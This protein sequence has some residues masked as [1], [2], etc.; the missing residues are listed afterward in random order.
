MTDVVKLLDDCGLDYIEKTVAL[1][2][3]DI[4]QSIAFMQVRDEAIN[5]T[6]VQRYAQDLVA[7]DEFPPI[8]VHQNGQ[9]RML[10]DDGNHRVR[11]AVIANRD[12][13]NA[14]VLT[15]PTTAQLKE[16]RRRANAIHGAGLSES[17]RLRLAVD[18]IIRDGVT[19]ETAAR[20]TKADLNRIKAAVQTKRADDRIRS[21]VP[22]A[23]KLPQKSRER[24]DDIKS[25]EVLK[26]AADA[27]MLAGAPAKD[28]STLVRK[29][30]S[31]REVSD[32]KAVIQ[33]FKREH[34]QQVRE[35]AGGIVRT[36]EPVITYR[37]GRGMV[38]GALRKDMQI[39]ASW[40][41]ANLSDADRAE[42]RKEALSTAAVLRGLAKVL[43]G[44]PA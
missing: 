30:N 24:L 5:P 29:V 27:V 41:S 23:S 22:K 12:S 28:V 31:K 3:I 34:R 21:V 18:A 39:V 43:E 42:W 25:D 17:E 8:V 26:V 7:G 4:D 19:F 20:S 13:V 15:D 33:E 9:S 10:V 37:R 44:G 40:A 1:A 14:L 2:D 6:T 32:Q 38:E 36:P 16:F 35:T 11:A